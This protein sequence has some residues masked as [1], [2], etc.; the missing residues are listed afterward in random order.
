MVLCRPEMTGLKKPGS[1]GEEEVDV[2]TP[3]YFPQGNQL[4]AGRVAGP[5]L[6]LAECAGADGDALQDVALP[7]D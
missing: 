6:D 7:L 4:F 5:L 3:R 2:I 1:A